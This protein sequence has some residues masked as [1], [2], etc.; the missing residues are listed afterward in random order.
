MEAR[1][2]K[3][4][5]KPVRKIDG[6]GSEITE[7]FD[8]TKINI[9]LKQ[10]SLDI[11]IKRM[12][13]NRIDLNTE[14]QRNKDLWDKV[15]K[16]RLIESILVRIPLP[17][18]YFDGTDDNDWKV[19]DGLQRLN[20]LKRFVIDKDLKLTDL[21]FL[22]QFEGKGYDD[23]P[24]YMRGRIDETQITAYVINPGTPQEAIFNIFKRINTG[25][26]MLSPQEIRH[27]L[28]QGIP[29]DFVRELAE[30]DEFNRVY[31]KKEKQKRM[32][33]RELV[34]RFIGFCYNFRKYT[35][36]LDAFLNEAMGNLAKL[37]V[38][39]REQI[40]MDFIK[41]MNAARSI[42]GDEAFKKINEVGRKPRFTKLLFDTWAVNLAKLDE[43]EINR[44]ILEKE[45]V[46]EKFI[47]ILNNDEEF[48]NAMNVA[49]GKY[50]SVER[51]INTIKKMLQGIL[52]D[53][54]N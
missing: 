34:T 11:L 53:P 23:L 24:L 1:I 40:K 41:A 9:I 48:N 2:Q 49:T 39:E 37:P 16:S 7:P 31:K 42:F 43:D 30:L 15:A 21:E 38:E 29:A 47:E 51:R 19:V 25:G 20:T 22:N 13:N 28:N 33:D 36:D 17:A 46:K 4:S 45:K 52:N 54:G 18:F 3:I 26:L 32:Q 35:K 6:Q 44:L 27:A 12:E 5:G 10:L 14:F 50:S 8:P